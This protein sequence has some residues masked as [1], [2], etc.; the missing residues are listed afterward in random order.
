MR[1]GHLQ[2]V[3]KNTRSK[4]SLEEQGNL[5]TSA[6]NCPTCSFTLKVSPTD[7]TQELVTDA[8]ESYN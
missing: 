6:E 4:H 5:I 1:G 3:T 2:K 8:M 7:L